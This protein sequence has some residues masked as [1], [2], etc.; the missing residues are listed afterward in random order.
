MPAGKFC[1]PFYRT[2]LEK[3]LTFF[4]APDPEDVQWVRGSDGKMFPLDTLKKM[5][6]PVK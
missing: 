3:I 6:I 1:C 5:E 2:R 4:R